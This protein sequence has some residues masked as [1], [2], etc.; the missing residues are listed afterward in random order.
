MA[1]TGDDWE[2]LVTWTTS[3]FLPNTAPIHV[4]HVEWVPGDRITTVP[5]E[6]PRDGYKRVPRFTGETE[7]PITPSA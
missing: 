5:A 2:A 4:K 3:V 6:E 7:P 1:E